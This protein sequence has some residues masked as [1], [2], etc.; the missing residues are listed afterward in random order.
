MH[1][2]TF[3]LLGSNRPL[4]RPKRSLGI[5]QTF[6]V[7]FNLNCDGFEVLVLIEAARVHT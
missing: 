7:L 2:L 5:S 4:P 3:F 1:F 6:E